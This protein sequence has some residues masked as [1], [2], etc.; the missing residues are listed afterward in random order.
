MWYDLCLSVRR[1]SR[2]GRIRG[3]PAQR[4]GREKLDLSLLSRIYFL[5]RDVYVMM[6]GKQTEIANIY[7]HIYIYCHGNTVAIM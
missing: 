5:A 3:E 2:E 7:T 6:I 4:G 1:K